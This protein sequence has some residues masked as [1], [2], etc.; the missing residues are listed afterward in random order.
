MSGF[1]GNCSF[2][3]DELAKTNMLNHVEGISESLNGKEGFFNPT[4][5]Y[6]KRKN[7]FEQ[8]LCR[9]GLVRSKAVSLTSGQ[10][11]NLAISQFHE[12]PSNTFD[13]VSLQIFKYQRA[14]IVSNQKTLQVI[15]VNIERV[16]RK[17]RSAG[18]GIVD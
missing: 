15:R 7:A 12:L 10:L 4:L 18:K 1:I 14:R 8:F 13:V 17:N 9:P 3:R 6:L 11:K 5:F 2:V 16:Q